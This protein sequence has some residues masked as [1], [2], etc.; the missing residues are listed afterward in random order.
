[1]KNKTRVLRFT[2][3][4]IS[5]FG[6][7]CSIAVMFPQV[8]KT[9]IRLAEEYLI[10][11]KVNFYDDWMM[12]LSAWARGCITLILIVDFF[13][14][15]PAGRKLFNATTL[16]IKTCLREADLKRL[17]KP[18]LLLSGLSALGM[19]SV[20]RANFSY[21]DD[22]DRAATGYH[23]WN[24]WSRHVDDILS[25]FIHADPIL[26]DISPLPQILGML[27]S[28]AAAVICVD[29]LGGKTRGKKISIPALISGLSIIISPYFLEN[30]S[31]KFD[32]PY[33]GLSLFFSVLPFLFIP[34]RK[35]FVFSSV[36]SLC[37][38][39][40][41]YQ[42]SSGIY[43]L[44]VIAIC[45]RDW[46]YRRKAGKETAVFA[47][48]GALSFCAA[49]LLFRFCFMVAGSTGHGVSTAMLPADVFVP[50]VWKN[51]QT[52][53]KTINSDF[54]VIWK[55]LIAAVCLCFIAHSVKHTKQRRWVS[56]LVCLGVMALSFALSYGAYL[57]LESLLFAPRALYGFCVFI[58]LLGICAV[59]E[60]SKSAF[61]CVFALNWCFFAFAF[62]YGNALADQ[63]RWNDFRV[64]L[65]LTD[66]NHLFHDNTKDTR[67]AFQNETGFGPVTENIARH[68]PLIKRL[69]PQSLRYHV[70]HYLIDYY[71]F[72]TWEKTS[73][74]L[75][76]KDLPVVLDTY[77]HTIKSDGA[78]ILVVFK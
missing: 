20:I 67:I 13:A 53:A 62:S 34:S 19:A 25:T 41:T 32:A 2:L 48:L 1:M 47:G 76:T 36:A 75:T 9:I 30:L 55:V 37:L 3:A 24:G 29:V 65:V 33:M 22:I 14:L 23:G 51:L 18:A 16:D 58:A 69:V 73:R 26:T 71:H 72:G 78:N 52:Y 68:A 12:T 28:A 6:I 50:G 64:E 70:M 59:S 63:K 4:I 27:F 56:L 44:M 31:Y 40:M 45:F 49:M 38:M 60:K 66:L 39:C 74:S 54:S 11:R 61:V 10:H 7:V 43:V 42:A 77:Y 8:Q 57:F 35:A 21:V 5:A 17:I 46:N 15:V